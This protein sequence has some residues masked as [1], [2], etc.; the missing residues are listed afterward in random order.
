[1]VLRWF[2]LLIHKSFNEKVKKQI[3]IQNDIAVYQKV[4]EGK[5]HIVGDE[6]IV[7]FLAKEDLSKLSFQHYIEKCLQIQK[8]TT[9][10]HV[11][12]VKEFITSGEAV[13]VSAHGDREELD[14]TT[15]TQHFT[16]SKLHSRI[17][18]LRIV[19]KNSPI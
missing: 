10:S 13:A 4:F 5:M 18:P 2:A 9:K 8:S 12:K 1:M 19:E 16:S 14:D 17:G 11:S 3:I 15:I 6:R 7:E